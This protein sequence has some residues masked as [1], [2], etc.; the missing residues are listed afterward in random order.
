MSCTMVVQWYMCPEP[1]DLP[2]SACFK[3][4]WVSELSSASVVLILPWDTEAEHFQ[5]IHL[6]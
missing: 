4:F 6:F 1:L 3:T 5:I 2:T